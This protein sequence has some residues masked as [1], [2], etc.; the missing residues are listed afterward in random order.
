MARRHL[1]DVLEHGP[2]GFEAQK[3]LLMERLT[4]PRRGDTRSKQ[5][6]R[7]RS[8]VESPLIP[9]VVQRLDTETI[10][11]GNQQTVALIPQH[12]GKLPAQVFHERGAVILV[13][14]QRDLAVGM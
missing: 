8:E 14:V 5:G 3:E 13:Q 4:I 7:F 11:G 12:E 6:L 1:S 9:R 10:A 2:V